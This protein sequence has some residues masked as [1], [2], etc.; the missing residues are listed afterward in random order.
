M[1][2]ECFRDPCNPAKRPFRTVVLWFYAPRMKTEL[3]TCVSCGAEAH[4]AS[5]PPS[6]EGFQPGDVIAFVCSDC[7][8]RMDI[9]FEEDEGP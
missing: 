2:G 3:V 7:G 1:Y 6:E 4:P 9:V 8:E 5:Y